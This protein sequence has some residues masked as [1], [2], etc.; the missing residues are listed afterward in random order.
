MGEVGGF[1]LAEATIGNEQARQLL[2][3]VAHARQGGAAPSV[4]SP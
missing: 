1:L 4:P 3:Y 2:S